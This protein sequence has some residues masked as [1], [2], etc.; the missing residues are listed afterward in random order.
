M[1]HTGEQGTSHIYLP[2]ERR[3]GYCNARYSL[4]NTGRGEHVALTCG[5]GGI[6]PTRGKS[7]PPST[8]GAYAPLAWKIKQT[9]KTGIKVYAF[10]LWNNHHKIQPLC[11]QRVSKLGSER[12]C[13]RRTEFKAALGKGEFPISDTRVQLTWSQS[14]PSDHTASTASTP[15][16]KEKIILLAQKPSKSNS[17]QL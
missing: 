4:A 14:A 15:L 7:C 16:F 17:Q 10:S 11:H 3:C 13:F 12:T 8:S 1:I 5:P 2:Q 9:S 6:V